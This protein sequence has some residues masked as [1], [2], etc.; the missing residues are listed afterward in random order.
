MIGWKLSLAQIC[1]VS[2]DRCFFK[3]G[4][5]D[6]VQK[7]TFSREFG[8]NLAFPGRQG[9]FCADTSKGFFL[10]RMLQASTQNPE[11]TLPISYRFLIY[12]LH[13]FHALHI[14]FSL[15]ILHTSTYI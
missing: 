8:N 3:E 2:Y 4:S 6:S 5:S 13:M 11:H 9:A 14:R 12:T 1:K 10:L 7:N 15:F